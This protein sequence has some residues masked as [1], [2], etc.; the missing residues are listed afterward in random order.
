MLDIQ[1]FIIKAQSVVCPQCNE[2]FATP[3]LAK[4]KKLT[5]DSQVETDLHRV[6]PDPF[7][8]STFVAVCPACLYAW[9]FAAFAP[10]Y[11]I[12]DLVPETP[13]I[14]F[15]KKF[16]LA[17]LSG[18]NNGAHALDRAMLALNGCWCAR[19]AHVLA[20]IANS[21]EAV[22]DNTRW[23]TLAKQELEEA[24]ADQ[25]WQGNR[26]RYQYILGEVL[27]QLGEF[28]KAI[29]CFETV[30]R[31][32]MLPRQL[33]VHQIK[34]A[35]AQQSQPDFLPPY[36]VEMIFLPKPQVIEIAPEALAEQA[37][38]KAQ[39]TEVVNVPTPHS[40]PA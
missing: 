32:S 39:V 7:I 29:K 15:P 30:D 18:R 11:I 12:P 10:H 38:Q 21:A 22:A 17:V 23:L 33:V 5:T 6:L 25:E 19:E 2:V 4:M 1:G 9:W 36:L 31:R 20:G 3:D 8:R 40:I 14:E 26:N 27:R 16:A 34:M 24:L 13:S 28:E 37:E 35:Q